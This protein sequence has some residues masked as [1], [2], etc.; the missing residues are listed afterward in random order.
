MTV[1]HHPTYSHMPRTC[2]LLDDLACQTHKAAAG[3]RI[4]TASTVLGLH[5]AEGAQVRP[6]TAAKLINEAE[7]D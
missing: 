7:S 1:H 2:T 3:C 4:Q 6:A 5:T